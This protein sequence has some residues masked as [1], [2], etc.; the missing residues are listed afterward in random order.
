MDLEVTVE[1]PA[2]RAAGF[3]D[4]KVRVVLENAQTLRFE[5][6]EFDDG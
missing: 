4:D 5:R 1:I 6:A 3:P 2:R